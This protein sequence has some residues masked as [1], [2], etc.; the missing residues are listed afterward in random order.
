M[1]SLGA[2]IKANDGMCSPALRQRVNEMP[3]ATI[4]ETKPQH[5]SVSRR[6]HAVERLLEQPFPPLSD[7]RRGGIGGFGLR[8]FQQRGVVPQGPDCGSNVLPVETITR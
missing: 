8:Q 1:T 4:A 5:G 6:A 2:A 7:R 3:L